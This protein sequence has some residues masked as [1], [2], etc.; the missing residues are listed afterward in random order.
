MSAAESGFVSV[1]VKSNVFSVFSSH[2][3]H[4]LLYDVVVSSF[5]PGF[6][7]G[8]VGVTSRSVPVASDRFGFEVAV[9]SVALS[10]SFDD[11]SSQPHVVSALDSF[12]DSHLILPLG[13]SNFGIDSGDL[14][15]SVEEASVGHF[16]HF[17]SESV[18]GSHSAVVL[19]LG[20]GES[21]LWPSVGS[22]NEVAFLGSQEEFLLDSEPRVVLLCV[23]HHFVREVSE[24][25]SGRSDF[26]VDESFAE[27]EDGVAVHSEGVLHVADWFQPDL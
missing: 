19:A 6:V 9:D 2:F 15:P 20:H 18:G 13:R 8:E 12:C 5:T 10:D 11:V 23:F 4:T 7:G 3:G 26:V 21:V 24:V 22:G 25:V 27:N 16:D 17:S 1:S 14:Q